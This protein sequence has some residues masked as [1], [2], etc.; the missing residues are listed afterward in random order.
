MN[1]TQMIAIV[2][3]R[4]VAALSLLILL[5]AAVFAYSKWQP[6]QY[7]ATA[8]VMIDARPDDPVTSPGTGGAALSGSYMGTQIDLLQSERVAQR[9]IK[10]LK[11]DDDPGYRAQWQTSTHAR[12]DYDAWLAEQ[13]LKKLD[14]KPSR[15]SNVVN[16]G[17]LSTDP[18]FAAAAANAFVRAYVDTNLELKVEPA[19]QYNIFFDERAKQLRGSLEEAQA[20]LSAY[21]QSHGIIA[22]DDKLDVESARLSE[23]SSQVVTLQGVAAESSSRHGQSGANSQE[24]LGNITIGTLTAEL[25]RQQAR[26]S[27]LKEHLGER[28]P[29]VVEL[30]ANIAQLR[31]QVDSETSR[32]S[33]SL[34]VNTAVDRSRL[35]SAQAALNEQ[36]ARVLQLRSRRDEASVLLRDVDSAQRAYDATLA[37]VTQTNLESQNTFTNVSIVKTASEP[38]F[39][40]SPRVML[41]TAVAFV[42]GCMLA[43]AFALLREYADRRLRFDS[44]VTEALRVPLLVR[45]PDSGSRSNSRAHAAGLQGRVSRMIHSL[46]GGAS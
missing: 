38:P 5:V 20:R 19:K 17:Y 4:R 23:L 12:G 24:V 43:V 9:V 6:R 1:P 45:L 21:Q 11:L 26:L 18:R 29:Q 22:T 15:D 28:N 31:N 46:P 25:S 39:A 40:A 10:L 37:R 44:D 2:V 36:R 16:I 41:N 30:Q 3:G 32:V 7:L 33:G 8:A 35:A 13:L 14:V 27:E 34:G 42:V